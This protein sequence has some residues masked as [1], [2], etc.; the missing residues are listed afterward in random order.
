[1]SNGFEVMDSGIYQV[2]SVDDQNVRTCKMV[3]PREVFVKA[4]Q[5][6]VLEDS[7]ENSG[8]CCFGVRESENKER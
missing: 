7:Y 2:I 4:Y 1:M 8:G 6:Y 3:I 5:K